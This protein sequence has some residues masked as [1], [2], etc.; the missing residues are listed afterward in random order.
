MHSSPAGSMPQAAS[1]TRPRKNAREFPSGR[2]TRSR[3]RSLVETEARRELDP[4]PRS[5]RLDRSRRQ[6]PRACSLEDPFPEASSHRAFL[7]NPAI[8]K[9]TLRVKPAVHPRPSGAGD[10]S[11]LVMACASGSAKAEEG[12]ED[13]GHT[14][15]TLHGS[16]LRRVENHAPITTESGTKKNAPEFPPGRST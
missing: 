6:T 10:M 13:D 7:N 2:S 12:R 14:G 11:G 16:L 15:N 8:Q 3:M 5:S 4:R 9:T 1:R